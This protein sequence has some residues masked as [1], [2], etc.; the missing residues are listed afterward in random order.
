M[1]GAATYFDWPKPLV[2]SVISETAHVTGL[3]KSKPNK[4][5]RGKYK[6]TGS[7]TL[8]FLGVES[9]EL[10]FRERIRV[11]NKDD[12]SILIE[13]LGGKSEVPR[14]LPIK[15]SS[16]LK[17]GSITAV[18]SGD[19]FAY[20]TGLSFGRVSLSRG[21]LTIRGYKTLYGIA[22]LKCIYRCTRKNRQEEGSI[23][24]VFIRPCEGQLYETFPKEKGKNPTI[25]IA[26]GTIASIC[27]DLKDNGVKDVFLPFK[28]DDESKGC[29]CSKTD[30]PL[31]I[32][33][34]P[35][36][37][38]TTDGTFKDAKV[39][40]G[41]LLYSSNLYPERISPRFKRAFEVDFDPIGALINT[42]AC[43]GL[44]FHAWFPVFK[45]PFAAKIA[46]QKASGW[47][48]TYDGDLFDNFADPANAEVVAYEL[49]LLEEIT[50]KYP[51]V[52]INLDYIR[53]TDVSPPLGYGLVKDPASITAF[54][55]QVKSRS[56]NL[57]ISADV[58]PYGGITTTLLTDKFSLDSLGRGSN[59]RE[60]L[61][62]EEMIGSLDMVMPMDYSRFSVGS[63]GDIT[64]SIKE[65]KTNH[66]GIQ[67]M[68][69]L[70]GWSINQDADGFLTDLAADIESSGGGEGI[71][72]FTYESALKDAKCK[73][74]GRLLG[75]LK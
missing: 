46:R 25:N 56:P 61:G 21:I 18:P 33:E 6:C 44:R 66:P 65:I 19:D 1:I 23:T 29:G 20:V 60:A 54:V 68:P 74:L 75:K 4:K 3:S 67:V 53:Y 36:N 51:V 28:V 7:R 40:A 37:V 17:S 32:G 41:Q 15:V 45:D 11:T 27:R 48:G 2:E 49:A 13:T 31:G 5:I 72:I 14:N 39:E 8:Y 71:G 59:T 10:T 26:G 16:E 58:F 63:P 70:R 30:Q 12:D 69:I 42:S 64:D 24:A 34:E 47:I 35:G 55:Q 50:K 22:A 73:G 52:G 43:G 57:T 38:C 62:Q 9:S